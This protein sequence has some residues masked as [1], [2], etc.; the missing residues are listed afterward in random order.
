MSSE[1]TTNTTAGSLLQLVTFK[2]AEEEYGVDILSVQEIIRHTGITKV[3]SAPAFVE[4]IL[5]LR[6]RVI[7]IIDIRK[8]FGLA[9]IEPDQQT[10]IVVFALESGVIGC[11]VDSVS[12]VL[13]LPSAM[14]DEP[15]AVIAGVDSKYILGVGRLDD[16]LL[17]LLDFGQVLTGEELDALH[18]QETH[19]QQSVNYSHDTVPAHQ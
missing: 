7:P 1:S 9:A 16:R 13:R 2:V 4:G 10:R 3:P 18:G 8:R 17:I 5:N 12:E 19:A 11:L 6:G 15:P 14:V